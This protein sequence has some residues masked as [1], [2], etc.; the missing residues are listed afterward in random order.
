MYLFTL[1]PLYDF[2]YLEN[3]EQMCWQ[4]VVFKVIM[5]GTYVDTFVN[6]S[7]IRD[8]IMPKVKLSTLSPTVTLQ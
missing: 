3:L 8:S 1:G 4:G 2:K 7:K 5:P 6:P